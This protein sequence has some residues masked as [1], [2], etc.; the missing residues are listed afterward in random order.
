[1]EQKNRRKGIV[2]MGQLIGLVKPLLPLM[3]LAILL[4]V[5]GYLCAIFFNHSY[6]VWNV[7]WIVR[8]SAAKRGRD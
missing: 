6:R 1:M 5:L 4:G 8:D 3:S 2:I 7:I